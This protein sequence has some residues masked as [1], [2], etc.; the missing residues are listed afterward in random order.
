MLTEHAV[1]DE[2][3]NDLRRAAECRV[4]DLRDLLRDVPLT[5]PQRQLFDEITI[6]IQLAYAEWCQAVK[7]QAGRE[8][9]APR[10]MSGV[11]DLDLS[12]V[13]ETKDA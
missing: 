4:Q 5:G 6:D 2:S 9:P 10:V 1:T 3:T 13:V 11:I 12:D 7:I 8:R